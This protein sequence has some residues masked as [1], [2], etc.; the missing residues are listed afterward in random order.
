M[1]QLT[2]ALGL[3]VIGLSA[4][5]LAADKIPSQFHGFWE[6]AEMCET[7]MEIGVPDTGAIIDSDSI[8][9]YEASCSVEKVTQVGVNEVTVNLMCSEAEGEYKRTDNLKLYDGQF[10]VITYENYEPG[11]RLV[12]CDK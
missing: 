5:V 11:S 1:K 2:L 7:A 3:A 9:G 8:S 6:K 4:P 12:R 10:L